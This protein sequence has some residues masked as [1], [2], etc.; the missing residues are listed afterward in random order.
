MR[1]PTGQNRNDSTLVGASKQHQ[2]GSGLRVASSL[3]GMLLTP[4][5]LMSNFATADD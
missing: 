4:A 2:V 5:G 3:T 1:L